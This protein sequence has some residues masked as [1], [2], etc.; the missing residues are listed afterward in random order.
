MDEIHGAIAQAIERLESMP[1]FVAAA[2]ESAPP[3]TL[4]TRAVQGEF[5]LVEH[6]CHLRDLDRDAYL[7]RVRRILEEPDPVLEPFHGEVIAA[8]RNYRAQD[9]HRAAR[10]FAA[11]RRE[12]TA[13][14][15][16]ASATELQR[17][18]TFGERPITLRGLVA[19]MEEHD[20]GHRE[21]IERLLDRLDGG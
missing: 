9:A 14:L 13:L 5:A 18:A 1:G 19:M 6:A 21:E 12:L 3:G 16:A 15:A 7:L 2:L 10:E 20:R 17:R 8:E 11:A 4:G